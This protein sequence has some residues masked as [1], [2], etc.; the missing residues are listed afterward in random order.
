MR[1]MLRGSRP[2]DFTSD[3]G[4]KVQGVRL[5]VSFPSDGVAG[6]ETAA[7]FVRAGMPLPKLEVGKPYNA[8]FSNKGKLIGIS[9]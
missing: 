1:I 4:D 6:E 2:L 7:F 3:N 5:F 9:E 8:E